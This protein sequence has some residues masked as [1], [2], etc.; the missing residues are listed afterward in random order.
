MLFFP[1]QLLRVYNSQC[2]FHAPAQR[3]W[4]A[5]FAAISEALMLSQPLARLPIQFQTRAPGTAGATPGR[6]SAVPELSETIRSL[7]GVPCLAF[8]ALRDG[9]LSSPRRLWE[10]RPGE[11]TDF[12]HPRR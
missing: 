12:E 3:S 1:S 2:N 10:L 4:T 9:E 7:P 6:V 11:G 8:T 5:I